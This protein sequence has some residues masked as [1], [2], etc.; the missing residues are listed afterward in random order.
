MSRKFLQR[1]SILT[2]LLI[3]VTPLGA[4]AA[5]VNV[6]VQAAHKVN[7]LNVTKKWY[8]PRA[9]KGEYQKQKLT[10]KSHTYRGLVAEKGTHYAFNRYAFLADGRSSAGY[11]RIKYLGPRAEPQGVA[12]VG[13]YMYIQ[14]TF[15]RKRKKHESKL[16]A[17]RVSNKR[18]GRIVR[19]NLSVINKF[20]NKEGKHDKVVRVLVKAKKYMYPLPYNSKSKKGRKQLKIRKKRIKQAKKKLGKKNYKI[21]SAITLGPKY[22]TGHGQSFA[23]NPRDKKHLYNAAYDLSKDTGKK[24]HAIRINRISRTT[25][26]PDKRWNLKIRLR[27]TNWVKF[28]G[29]KLWPYGAKTTGYLQMH[30]F[31]F[32][33]QGRFYFTSKSNKNNPSKSRLKRRKAYKPNSHESTR[34]TDI[35]RRVYIYQG[36]LRSRGA[37]ISIVQEVSNAI[38]SISQGMSYSAKKNRI[39]LIYDSA[40]MSLSVSKLGTSMSSKKMN[41]T[42]LQAKYYRESEGMGI[43]SSGHGYL[44]LNRVAESDRSKTVVK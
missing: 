11:H 2:M 23:Y 4:E 17:K 41:F 38:G 31:T 1:V 9:N 16:H 32:D 27:K 29:I 35:G 43:T 13:H 36:R 8:R 30:D 14:M 44:I 22:Y 21:F 18:H 39:F 10:G 42:V 5:T 3:L 24:A 34:A 15:K 40:F 6:T 19:Y 7:T 12:I 25:L 33:R 28:L 37:R 26:R 20:V